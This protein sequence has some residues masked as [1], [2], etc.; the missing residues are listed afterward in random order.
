MVLTIQWRANPDKILRK[1]KSEI[2]L[3]LFCEARPTSDRQLVFLV[4]RTRKHFQM[5][6]IWLLNTIERSLSKKK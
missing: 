4:R 3:P 1:V 5:L 6:S 2:G